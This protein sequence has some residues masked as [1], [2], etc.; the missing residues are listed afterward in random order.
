MTDTLNGRYELTETVGAGGMGAVYRA[1]DNRLGRTVAVKVL[2][3]GAPA[4]GIAR[5]R[6]RSEANLAASINHPGVA[7]VY[8]F[9]E[10]TA[11]HDAR[12]FI[13]MQFIE[14]HTLAQ[15]LREQGAMSVQQVMSVVVQVAEGLQAAHDAGIVHRDLKPANI[16]LTPAG[17]TVLVDFGI[18]HSAGSEPLT[19]TGTLIGTAD[20]MSPE[21]AAGRRATAQSDL[22]SLGVVAFHCLS[23]ASPF[24]R[25]SH[26]ATALAHLN[27]DLPALGPHVPVEVT[28]LLESLTAKDPS[29]RPE[30]AAAVALRA[31]AIGADTA[32]DLP[33]TFELPA[34]VATAAAHTASSSSQGPTSR[35]RRPVVAYAGVGAVLLALVLVGVDKLQASGDAVVPNVV[36]LD[37]DD[38]A[39][40]LHDAGMDV[41]PKTV[42]QAGQPADQVIAQQPGPGRPGSDDALVQISVASGKVAVAAE[43]V[44]G[45]TYA[46]GAAALEKLGLAVSRRDVVQSTGTG[47]VVALDRSGRLA[48]GTSVT[49][50][51]A[52]APAAVTAR[53]SETSAPAAS[54]SSA[55][56]GKLDKKHKTKG[57][58]KKKK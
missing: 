5:S 17:R 34:P 57:K 15:L 23:G 18:A 14:G 21:Q 26:I 24:R 12:T 49:L 58:S 19:S 51:V 35:R 8:D 50:S 40:R 16:M 38:A 28:A 31:A 3:G 32:I 39:A 13:V 11:T 44:I 7:Q 25:E 27:D 54:G 10:G 55:D 9:D 52:V 53:T 45:L 48:E 33:T 42:D 47:T 41:R 29:Q 6:M 30:T 20:Y 56:S 46:D 43:D 37:V 2:R 36:G 22:Y 1:T 4:D